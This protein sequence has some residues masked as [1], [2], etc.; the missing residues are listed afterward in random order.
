MLKSISKWQLLTR[1]LFQLRKLEL[2][3]QE[4]TQSGE[5]FLE[6]LR[7]SCTSAK[8][9]DLR[10]YCQN[11]EWQLRAC[12]GTYISR[13]FPYKPRE[14]HYL[15]VFSTPNTN[16]DGSPW[17]IDDFLHESRN[18]FPKVTYTALTNSNWQNLVKLWV[19]VKLREDCVKHCEELKVLS[20]I[21][22]WKSN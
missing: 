8:Q 20:E 4:H 15:H 22:S 13:P 14:G 6:Y 16:E 11:T 21:E 3:L 9:G 12:D 1:L 18:C 5:L 10:D 19:T 2:F 17:D 7:E